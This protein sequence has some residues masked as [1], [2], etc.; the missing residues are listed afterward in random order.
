M[1]NVQLIGR[2]TKDPELKVIG[3]DLPIATFSLAV[4]K[5]FK[6]D[7]ADFI[8]CKAFGKT[9]DFIGKYFSKGKK[10][11]LTGR[12]ESGSYQNKEGKT[13][14]TLEVVVE[15]TE[16]VEPRHTDELQRGKESEAIDTDGF[17]SVPDGAYSPF[18]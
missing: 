8:P 18:I 4:D 10:I 6:R 17:V 7:N 15:N 11:A 2:F 13:V 1:N 14:Y 9:A 12:L 3:D 16:F 5:R